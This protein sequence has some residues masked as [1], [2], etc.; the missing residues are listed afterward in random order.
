MS[1]LNCRDTPL[2]ALFSVCQSVN[3]YASN[4]LILNTSSDSNRGETK[5]SAKIL[6]SGNS[7]F[8]KIKR[9]TVSLE[10]H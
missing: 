9:K 2:I 3:R 6:A 10:T 7:T 5:N 4:Y 8:E 1:C